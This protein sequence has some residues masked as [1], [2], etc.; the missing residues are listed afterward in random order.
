MAERYAGDLFSAVVSTSGLAPIIATAVI[1][2][3]C[4]RAGIDPAAGINRAK[5]TQALQSIETSLRVYLP[6]PEV[7]ERIAAM[8]RLMG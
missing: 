8:K 1:R 6:A 5:L 4:L 7:A 3:A 2:R